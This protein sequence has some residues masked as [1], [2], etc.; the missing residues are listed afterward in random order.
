V[1]LKGQ[2]PGAAAQALLERLREAEAA[3]VPAEAALIARY[4]RPIQVPPG[5]RK[6][7]SR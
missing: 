7:G 1:T 4:A 3:L 2:A 6:H 5:R